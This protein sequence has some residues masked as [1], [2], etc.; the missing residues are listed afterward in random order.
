MLCCLLISQE[1]FVLAKQ[2][3]RQTGQHPQ[4][5]SEGGNLKSNGLQVFEVVEDPPKPGNRHGKETI[6]KGQVL[7][8][9]CIVRLRCFYPIGKKLLEMCWE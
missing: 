2:V 4:Q 1:L 8:L 3:N 6:V 5:Y 9:T 7:I